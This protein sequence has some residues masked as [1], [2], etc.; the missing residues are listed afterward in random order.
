MLY[1]FR[2]PGQRW[3]S[4]LLLLALGLLAAWW[5]AAARSPEPLVDVWVPVEP[6]LA[7]RYMPGQA[8]GPPI[9]A[10]AFVLLENKTGTVLY[11]KNAL[12]PRAPASTTKVLTALLALERGRLSDTVT[13]SPYAASTP[14]STA[15]LHAGQKITLEELLYGLLLRSGN[16]AAVA[17]AEHIGGSETAFARLMNER[18]S[19]LGATRSRFQNPHGLDKPGHFSTGLDLALIART[20]M[21]YQKFAQ[22]VGT[23][24]FATRAGT[25]YNTNRLLWGFAGAEGI[26][27]GTT[28][29]AGNC[30]VAAASRDG[31]QLISVVL[32]SGDRWRAS[33]ALL[34]Y[35]FENFHLVRLAEKGQVIAQIPLR[36]A[37]EP[38]VAVAREDLAVVVPDKDVN[39]LHTRLV[40][41][42]LSAPIR[43]LQDL[44][45]YEVTVDGQVIAEMPLWA[46]ASVPRRSPLLFLWRWWQ[47]VV[48]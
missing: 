24:E 42:P 23:R 38:I 16:D 20:G 47:G 46:A 35:G 18:A 22:I 39:R 45:R 14:G 19:E 21:L 31:M 34:D 41:K 36:E 29:L 37:A 1:H 40:L 2:I 10:A 13:V 17:I 27:T 43:R 7:I 26:K 11:A 48:G 44:G 9:D 25:W 6:E 8:E 5:W 15:D 3:Q 30:L 28:G 4:W 33:R 12:Q 32:D